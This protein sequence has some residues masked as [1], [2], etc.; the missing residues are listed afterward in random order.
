MIMSSFNL[1]E[2][3]ERYILESQDHFCVVLCLVLHYNT[4]GLKTSNTI[5]VKDVLPGSLAFHRYSMLL[6]L[7]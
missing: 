3:I 5:E 6:A 4:D 7:F 1:V 2:Y